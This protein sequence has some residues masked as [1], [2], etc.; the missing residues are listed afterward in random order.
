MI[1]VLRRD[2]GRA[3]ARR[4][5]PADALRRLV[6]SAVER[7][8][9]LDQVTARNRVL[10]TIREMLETLTG[11]VTVAEGLANALQALRRGLRADE[12]G[13][14]TRRR[15]HDGLARLCGHVRH[16]RHGDV[17]RPAAGRRAGDRRAPVDGAARTV[18]AGPGRRALAVSFTAPA[19]P[20]TLVATWEE[21]GVQ[22]RG[23][24][25]DRG[26]RALAAAGPRPRGGRARP[27]G[28]GHAAPLAPAPA[29]FPVTAQPRAPHAADGDPWLRHDPAASPT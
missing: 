8:A 22:R 18:G 14:L 20:S 3:G 10:E 2:A 15:R 29:R 1:T 7:E 17:R 25:A 5:R 27:P 4:A 11:P 19:G 6:S 24:G 9:L 26:R 13:L 16:R 21:L 28:G 23:D 12:V